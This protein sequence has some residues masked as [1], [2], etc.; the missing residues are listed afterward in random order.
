MKQN[1][2]TIDRTIRAVVIAPALL[3]IAYLVGFATVVGVLAT[4]LAVVM[5]GTAAVGF[6]PL[7]LPFHLH[8]DHRQGAGA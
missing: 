5:L 1:M 2:G 8:T 7:Y 3:V 6:C 4:V